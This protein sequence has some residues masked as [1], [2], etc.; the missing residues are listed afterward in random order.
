MKLNR[1]FY[2]KFDTFQLCVI[3]AVNVLFPF[4]L[5]V[6]KAPNMDNLIFKLD[7]PLAII[8]MVRIIQDEF[9]K[10]KINSQGRDV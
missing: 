3:L 5:S 8:L 6:L 1:T 2:Q 9:R 4:I 10:S 7:I